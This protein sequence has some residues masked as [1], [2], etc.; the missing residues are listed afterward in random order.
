[1]IR[2]DASFVGEWQQQQVGPSQWGNPFIG[3]ARYRLSAWVKLEDFEPDPS[4]TPG[5]QLGLELFQ[6]NGLALFAESQ[7]LDC[8][9]SE[10]LIGQRKVLRSSIDWTYIELVSRPCPPHALRAVVKCRLTGRGRAYFSNVRFE[11]AQD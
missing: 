4:Q 6:Y 2:N 5:P 9:W 1:V 10:P 11:I 7:M 3:G 8:G